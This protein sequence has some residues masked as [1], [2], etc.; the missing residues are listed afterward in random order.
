MSYDPT[1]DSSSTILLG[2][3]RAVVPVCGGINLE[4]LFSSIDNEVYGAGTKL[5]HNIVS[6][7]GLMNG[8]SSDLRTGLPS[9]MVEI[10]EPVRLLV[11]VVAATN[12]VDEVLKIDANIKK[13][14]DG[15]WLKL[16][17]WNKELNEMRW[18][19]AT[20][21]YKLFIPSSDE[22]PQINQYRDWFMGKS[23]HL[24]FAEINNSIRSV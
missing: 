16:V 2:I 3:L 8:T 10:H 22:L 13:A 15:E 1:I 12:Q 4:Y 20:G 7:L 17:V 24:D 11:I 6:L 23:D 18:R 21:E 19:L 5:P 14:F 9:Q